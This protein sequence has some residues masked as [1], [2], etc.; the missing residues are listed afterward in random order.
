VVSA[1]LRVGRL[2]VAQA[3]LLAWIGGRGAREALGL[4]PD[5]PDEALRLPSALF[6]PGVQLPLAGLGDSAELLCTARTADDRLALV[7]TV[8]GALVSRAQPVWTALLDELV[9]VGPSRVLLEAEGISQVGSSALAGLVR[10]AE[11][12]RA[13]GWRVDLLRCPPR[14]WLVIEMLGLDV[15]MGGFGSLSEALA[16]PIEPSRRAAA[17]PSW[18]LGLA[19]WGPE[20]C[21]RAA[22]AMAAAPAKDEPPDRRA[23]WRALAADVRTRGAWDVRRLDVRADWAPLDRAC[24]HAALADWIFGQL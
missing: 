24:V 7:V 16:A 8:R 3:E 17:T 21:A 9:A 14:I 19:R 5:A 1:G 12:A 6:Q 11:R 2:P 13:E 15:F 10:A 22:V 20:A 18:L 4:S 23:A